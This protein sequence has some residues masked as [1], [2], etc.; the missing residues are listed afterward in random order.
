MRRIFYTPKTYGII[1]SYKIAFELVLFSES[2]VSQ[3]YFE[4]ASI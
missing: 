1:D 2:S 4:L 3:I